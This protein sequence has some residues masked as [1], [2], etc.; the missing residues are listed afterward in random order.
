MLP[1]LAHCSLQTAPK[2]EFSLLHQSVQFELYSF[3][4]MVFLSDCSMRSSRNLRQLRVAT[5]CAVI[6]MARCG[7][8]RKST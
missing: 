2:F 8:E 7:S 4:V 5:C 6:V 1:R 3:L